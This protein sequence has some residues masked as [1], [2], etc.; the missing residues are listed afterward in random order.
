MA[1][2]IYK[3]KVKII[4]LIISDQRNI[5]SSIEWNRND[6]ALPIRNV[7]KVDRFWKKFQLNLSRVL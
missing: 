2:I 7:I 3:K 1:R 5:A 6:N 4:I